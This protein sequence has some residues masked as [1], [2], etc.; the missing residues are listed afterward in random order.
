M[1]INYL[2]ITVVITTYNL[3]RYID[4]CF[5]D[6]INQTMQ[7]FDVLIVDDNSSDGTR[8]KIEKWKLKFG[9]RLKTVYLESN[10]GMPALT[11]DVAL[12]SGLIDG[13]FV[14]FFDGDDRIDKYMLEKMVSVAIQENSD[15]V[16]CG[17]DRVDEKTG[18]CI[19]KEMVGF[20]RHITFSDEAYIIPYI[21]TSPWNKLWKYSIVRDLRFPDFKVGE[22]V[23]FNFRAYKKCSK[24]CFVDEVLIHY[25][26][27]DSSVISNTDEETIWRFAADLERLRKEADYVSKYIVEV[28][29]F[30]HIGLSMALRAADNKDIDLRKFLEKVHM[31]FSEI[32]FFKDNPYMKFKALKKNGMKGFMI[33]IALLSYKWH[34]F[35]MVLRCYR[36][37]GKNIKF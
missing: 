28:L 32:G 5:D 4:N 18:T 17:Y 29:I 33:Y 7:D 30:F 13:E 37:L 23:S 24:I 8:D 14:I 25:I 34:L 2:K 27:R 36:L 15:V 21:N 9:N 20:P 22:E 19:S 3:E 12:D 11:R 16:I 6:L 26:V 10:K 1:E 35:G 31:F